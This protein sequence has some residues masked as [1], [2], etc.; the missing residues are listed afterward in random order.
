MIL[1]H[2]PIAGLALMAILG[3]MYIGSTNLAKKN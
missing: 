3:A 2:D 1:D